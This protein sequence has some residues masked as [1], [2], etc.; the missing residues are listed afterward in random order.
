MSLMVMRRRVRNSLL[1]LV[2]LALA[3]GCSGGSKYLPVSG[4]VTVDG[5]AATPSGEGWSGT[6]MYHPDEEKGMKPEGPP[7]LGTINDQGGYS[8][9]SGPR[10]GVPPGWYKVTVD[11]KKA[12]N[13]KDPYS[14]PVPLIGKRFNDPKE[15]PFS[16]EVKPDAPA[17]HYDLPVTR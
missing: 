3:S 1:G 6:V 13:P 12:S 10:P 16:V 17:G 11:I 9:T 5:V 4:K 2:L 7:L 15:T 14:L 8:I